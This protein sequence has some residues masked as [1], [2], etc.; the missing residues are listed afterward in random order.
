MC[1]SPFFKLWDLVGYFSPLEKLHCRPCYGSI[2]Q[3][4]L[5]FAFISN[6]QSFIEQTNI[7]VLIYSFGF[8]WQQSSYKFEPAIHAICMASASVS[9]KVFSLLSRAQAETNNSLY[10]CSVLIGSFLFPMSRLQWGCIFQV[11]LGFVHIAQFQ[12]F[13]L[14]RHK[15]TKT[16]SLPLFPR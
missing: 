16:K 4:R 14:C 1:T 8:F 10:G 13:I 2:L 11:S 15:V 9:Q 12:Y 6:F 3:S 7:F 5:T